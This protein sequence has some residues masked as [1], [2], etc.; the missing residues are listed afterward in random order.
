[1]WQSFI[2]SR[3]VKTRRRPI[4]TKYPLTNER[5]WVDSLAAID[6]SFPTKQP[7]CSD[8][9]HET[10]RMCVRTIV[11]A[12]AFRHLSESSRNSAGHQL[13][14]WVERGN[15]VIVYSPR[16]TKYARELNRYTAARELL[17]DYNQRGLA[18]DVDASLAEAALDRIPG[19]P[20]R[21]S[22]DPHVLALAIV[23]RATVL[24]ACDGDLR[25]DFADNRVL[26]NV[27]RQKRRSVPDLID[28]VPEDTSA[29]SKRRRFLSRRRCPAT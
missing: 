5:T 17:R 7:D 14:R 2:S 23:S 3:L 4:C 28:N 8:C 12:S 15:G 25:E 16:Y 22:N 27:G 20:L 1:M 21:R 24:F 10:P 9:Q 13:R 19:H 11:D 18:M 26:S 29:A 6:G